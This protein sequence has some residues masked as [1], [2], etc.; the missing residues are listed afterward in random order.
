MRQHTD[1]AVLNLAAHANWMPE[2]RK[3]ME[4]GLQRI[5][6]FPLEW[7]AQAQQTES[8]ANLVPESNVHLATNCLSQATVNL[9]R[10]DVCVIPVSL[11]TLAWTR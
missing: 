5:Q 6:M 8:I 11:A 2:V 4:P 9:R 3:I 10:Y 7:E 1:C